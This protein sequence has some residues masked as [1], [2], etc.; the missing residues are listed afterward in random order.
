[1]KHVR[2]TRLGLAYSI[3]QLGLVWEHT[4]AAAEPSSLTLR[5]ERLATRIGRG[6]RGRLLP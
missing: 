5:M 3:Q 6:R 2:C 1:M 4:A